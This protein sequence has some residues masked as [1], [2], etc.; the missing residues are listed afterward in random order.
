MES[1]CDKHGREITI[2]IDDLDVVGLHEGIKIGELCFCE[3][4]CDK[5][6]SSIK[7]M[8]MNVTEEYQKAGIATEMMRVAVNFHGE[9]S[10]PLLS[11]SGGCKVAAEDYYTHEGAALISRCISLGI[12]KPDMAEEPE[13]DEWDS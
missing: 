8:N 12:L 11:A 4:D 7:L 13:I 3:I 1:F 5:S 2:V 6:P 9:F 10:R